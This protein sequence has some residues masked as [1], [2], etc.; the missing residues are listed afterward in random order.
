MERAIMNQTRTIRLPIHVIKQL[1]LCLRTSRKLAQT[2]DHEPSIEEIAEQLN[3]PV[4][5]VKRM[6]GFNQR[7]TS[8]DS[9]IGSDNG[10][11]LLDAIPGDGNL[12]PSRQLQD[13]D[14][15]EKL[16]LWL[17]HLNP[18]QRVVV[19]RRFGLW[20]Q[21]RAT[22][23]QVGDEIGVTRE[24]VRQIQIDALCRLRKIME[25]QGFSEEVL[26]ND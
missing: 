13:Q 26:Y 23:E 22:L 10:H 11:G 15:N 18:K 4:G 2:L 9:A 8:M 19:E 7:V 1:N 5:E 24:R 17:S 16:E 25:S 20:G 6:L 21:D 3:K 14:L 12:D